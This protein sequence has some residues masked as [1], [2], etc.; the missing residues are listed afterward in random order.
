LA[1]FQGTA[2]G[3]AFLANASSRSL[4]VAEYA[5]LWVITTSDVAYQ[6]DAGLEPTPATAH[7]FG[8]DN[9][10]VKFAG[11]APG[12]AR[13]GGGSDAYIGG[14]FADVAWGEAG[15]D[16]LYGYAGNDT[17]YGG[18]G[19]DTVD[20]GDG[21]DTAVLT[22]LRSAYAFSHA[23]GVIISS[24]PDGTD[25][26]SNVEFF[27]FDDGSFAAAAIGL[28]EVSLSPSVLRQA[29]GDAGSTSYSYTVTR[30]GD[31][32]GT[33]SVAWSVAGLG[34]N[35]AAAG[36]FAGG[37][38][39]SGVVDFAAGQTSA[40]I[41]VEVAGD[42]RVEPNE[43]FAVTLSAPSTGLS[44]GVGTAEGVILADD[45]VPRGDLDGDGR[46]DLV[47]Q[48]GSDFAVI[49]SSAAGGFGGT[50]ALGT[51]AAGY[52]FMGTAPIGGGSGS[53]AIWAKDGVGVLLGLGSAAPVSF[54]L[55]PVAQ[56]GAGWAYWQAADL[57]G[58]GRGE[59]VWKLG[60]SLGVTLLDAAGAKLGDFWLGSPGAGWTAIAAAALNGDANVDILWRNEGLGGALASTLV[61]P[62][63][64]SLVSGHWLSK[65]GDGWEYAGTGDFDADGRV[66]TVWTEAGGHIA[67]MFTAEDGTTTKGSYWF[68]KPGDG[69]DL[70]G[71]ADV[72][73]DG[74]S[75]TVWVN[76]A[77]G[78][79]V[80]TFV[81][82]ATVDGGGG[83]NADGIWWGLPGD[84]WRYGGTGDVNGDGRDDVVFEYL[85]GAAAAMLADANGGTSGAIYIGT[86]GQDWNFIG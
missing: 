33:Q 15:N 9:A 4:G 38:L 49:Y 56:P 78:G 36:D 64:T 5:G 82:R 28:A 59:L 73:G 74:R 27:Q 6:N 41:T 76:E 58:D 67:V 45:F 62:D 54:D 39:P 80:A 16:I 34:A 7:Q 43:R 8:D 40:T 47:W 55:L 85:D 79:S 24:G 63:G 66:D 11:A 26:F 51:L 17:L 10:E 84:G 86:V 22:G 46:D 57:S 75:D 81:T 20:G 44:I 83:V 14:A 29:E 65:P 70:A 42:T 52:E 13:L 23:G 68:S 18:T 31:V 2:A 30:T 1:A 77:L 35:A 32:A 37:V 25:V 3:A 71:V 72:N 12:N 61:G 60:E 69:W 48:A 53:D 21:T 50:Q 19:A